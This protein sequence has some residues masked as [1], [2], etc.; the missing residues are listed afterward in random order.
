MNI[1][2]IKDKRNPMPAATVMVISEL[3]HIFFLPFPSFLPVKQF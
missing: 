2:K 3:L 1:K